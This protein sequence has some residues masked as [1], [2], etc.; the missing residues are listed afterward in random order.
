MYKFTQVCIIWLIHE[1]KEGV[2]HAININ[3]SLNVA[4]GVEDTDTEVAPGQEVE[5]PESEPN[6]EEMEADNNAVDEW[7]NRS[8][9]HPRVC[10]KLYT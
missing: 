10:I 9:Q 4:L 6:G 2:W 7:A 5:E 8:L 3:L 1:S